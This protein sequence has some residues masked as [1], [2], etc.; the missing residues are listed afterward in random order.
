MQRDKMEWK[1]KKERER[2][3]L[4]LEISGD[5]VRQIDQKERSLVCPNSF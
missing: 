1:K 2:D 5:N 4:E 3:A